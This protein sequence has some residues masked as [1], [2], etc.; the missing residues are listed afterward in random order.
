MQMSACTFDVQSALKAQLTEALRR[1]KQLME[2]HHEV[3]Y[4]L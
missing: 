4:N 1:V 3:K 2:S